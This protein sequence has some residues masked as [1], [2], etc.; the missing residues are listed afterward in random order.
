MAGIDI[1]INWMWLGI[2][3]LAGSC[4]SSGKRSP[5]QRSWFAATG[6]QV[7]VDVNY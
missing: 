7:R 2:F 5:A 3:A 1:G 6:Q 4:T